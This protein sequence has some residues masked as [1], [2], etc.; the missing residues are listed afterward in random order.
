L[1]AVS[2][3]VITRRRPEE[4]ARLLERL[5][6]L[7]GDDPRVDVAVVDNDDAGSAAAP[8]EAARDRFAGELRYA[9]QPVP[10]YASARNAA[11]ALI[12]DAE[13]LAFIDDDE[14]PEAGWLERLQATARA[15]SADVVAGPVFTELPPD[16]PSAIVRS[17]V[18]NSQFGRQ[19]QDGAAMPLC[20]SGN[21]LVHRSVLDR[22][23]SGFDQR[24]D[25]SGG[26]DSHFFLRA[27]QAGC[28]IVW[29]PTAVVHETSG[30]ERT[31]PA[32]HVARARRIG[33]TRTMLDL[34]LRRS[35]KTLAIRAAACVKSLLAGAGLVVAGTVRRD[36]AIVL[37]GRYQLGLARGMAEAALPSR[38]P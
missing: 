11:V 32:W 15:H 16:A 18:M 37:R 2:V 7:Y 30:P 35:P 25:H 38:R 23:G 34:E 1:S 13:Y 5:A 17:N 28:K 9:L 22:V 29:C 3:A 12:G 6:V 24:F 31:E 33:Q 10:G 26:E 21:T 8:V 27:T 14:L 4:L 36:D 19:T 20:A